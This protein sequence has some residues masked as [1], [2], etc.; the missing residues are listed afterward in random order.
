MKNSAPLAGIRVLE[1]ARVL[2][3]P[4][5]GQT[6]A[7][8]GATV[9]KVE[10]PKGDETRHW[11]PPYAPDGAATYFHSCN[12]GKRSIVAD[13]KNAEDLE[14]IQ[15]LAQDADILVENFKLGGLKKFGLDYETLQGINPR[16]I[17]CSIT[18]FGQTGPKAHLPG[19]DFI[20][21]AMS[22]V[23]D[24]SGSPDGP[25]TKTGIALA[26][27]FT[28]LYGTVGIEA[29]LLQR[30]N[31]GRG[32]YIDMALYDS[33]LAVLANQASAFLMTGKSPTRLGNA[34]PSIV[35]YE[36]YD[37]IDGPLVIACGN[38]GQFTRMCSAFAVDWHQDA[39]FTTNPKRLENRVELSARMAALIAGF[40]RAEVLAKMEKAGVPAGPINTVG[41]ALSD[42]Q[43][44]AR[45]T[46]FE[47]DGNKS[48]E[49]PIRF[50]EISPPSRSAPPALD[51]HGDE[52]RKS[53]W[54]ED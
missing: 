7:D 11:G 22:G 45:N 46:I 54:D 28:A 3:G 12:R 5:I 21:Q 47:R 17:Y 1:L 18:G 15:N 40:Q 14:L 34:H 35:P 9:I 41:E 39:Q 49:L 25:P 38:D 29:A 36:V 42:P 53:G 19:Y 33:L 52:I 44:A 50:S 37:A 32:Q 43:V 31:T 23:M 26:D 27:L 24:V 10:S 13:F 8:L 2:A 51:Q 16:L 4:W 20:I 6:L 30:A 48:V